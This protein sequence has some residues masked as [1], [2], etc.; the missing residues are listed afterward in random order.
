MARTLRLVLLSAVMAFPAA[1]ARAGQPPEPADARFARAGRLMSA[2]KLEEAYAVLE[3]LGEEHAQRWGA[4]CRKRMDEI[5][6]LTAE[7]DAAL[8]QSGRLREAAETANGEQGPWLRMESGRTLFRVRLY[9]K[10]LE[11]AGAVMASRESRFRP[12]AMILAARCE[13]L[14]GRHAEAEK[15][16]RE[17]LAEKGASR[18]ER[19]LAWR[20]LEEMLSVPGRGEDLRGLVEEHIARGPEEPGVE[21]AVDRFVAAS[22]V[23]RKESLRLGK[24]LYGLVRSWPPGELSPGWVLTAAK[25]AEF[26]DCDYG[27]ADKLYRLVLERYPEVCFDLT[28]LRSGRR[29]ADAG[30]EVILASIARVEK[31]KRGELKPLKAPREKVRGASPDGALAALLCALREG[32]VADAGKYAA[33]RLAEELQNKRY[34][35]DRYALSDYRILEVKAIGPENADVIYEVAGELGVTRVLKRKAMAVRRDGQWKVSD[36]GM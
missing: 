36:L 33:G 13:S 5:R 7:R 2:G 35:Y 11:D 17:V 8:E 20:Q 1:S 30:R 34:P 29:G 19:E 21:E 18:A 32:D 16:Y 9:A 10:A 22:L 24:V 27:R 28:M 15:R 25:V 14:L 26:I 31:K 6:K 4:R 23:G 3:S 12:A